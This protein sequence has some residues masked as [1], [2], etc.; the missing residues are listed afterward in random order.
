MAKNRSNKSLPQRARSPIVQEIH[1]A[2]KISKV[3]AN[4]GIKKSK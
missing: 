1:S 3:K 4:N 2:N